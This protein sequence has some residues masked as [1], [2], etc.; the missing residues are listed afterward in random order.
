MADE[1]S[2]ETQRLLDWADRTI[3]QSRQLARERRTLVASANDR[4][5]DGGFASSL[6]SRPDGASHVEAAPIEPS[7]DA[8]DRLAG[9]AQ[10]A[11]DDAETLQPGVRIDEWINSTGLKPPQSGL[12]ERRGAGFTVGTFGRLDTYLSCRNVRD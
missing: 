9:F 3:A 12:E 1:F 8:P 10:Q 4:C 5:N 6:S 7:Q 11:K 2:P